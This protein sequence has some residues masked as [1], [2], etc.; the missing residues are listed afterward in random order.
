MP[1]AAIVP[2][3]KELLHGVV[4][5]KTVMRQLAAQR[6]KQ[7]AEDLARMPRCTSRKW[8]LIRRWTG[9][10]RQDFRQGFAPHATYLFK[11]ALVQDAAYGTLLRAPRR[12]LHC[13]IAE[14]VESQFGDLGDNQPEFLARHYTEA[15]LTNK[16]ITYWGIAGRK[17]AARS[18]MLEAIGQLRKGLEL[19]ATLPT[20]PSRLLY[21]LEFQS[22]F[23][24][25]LSAAKGDHV[26][27]NEFGPARDVAGHLLQ[28]AQARQDVEAQ[29]VANRPMGACLCQLG[30][31]GV[32]KPLN[33]EINSSVSPSSWHSSNAR[34]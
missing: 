25:A 13:H 27:R 29:L 33:T 17:S 30:E 1:A 15:G 26:A 24:G 21:E 22:A 5:G 8:K 18:A 31:F 10:L 20:G 7:I 6:R 9:S 2:N 14:T 12:A 11:H 28:L 34:E 3:V 23:G 16:A 19:V 4:D 32:D